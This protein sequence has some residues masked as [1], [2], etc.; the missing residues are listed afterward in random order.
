MV[1]IFTHCRVVGKLIYFLYNCTV[2]I[3]VQIRM[4]YIWVLD[5][6]VVDTIWTKRSVRRM[7]PLL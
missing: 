1:L 3:L 6:K 7:C 2:L 5:E 4:C